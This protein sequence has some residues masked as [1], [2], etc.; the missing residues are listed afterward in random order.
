MEGYQ[1]DLDKFFVKHAAKKCAKESLK[2][3]S[4]DCQDKP[5]KS[6][7]KGYQQAYMD[8]ALGESG[9]VPPVPPEEYWAAHYRTPEGY[10]EVQEWFTGYKLGSEHARADGRYDFN[11]IATPYSLAAWEQP[12]AEHWD[13]NVAYPEASMPSQPP[14]ETHPAPAATPSHRLPETTLPPPPVSG[15]QTPLKTV[16]QRHLPEPPPVQ[17]LPDR[18]PSAQPRPLVPQPRIQPPTAKPARRPSAGIQHT[19][20]PDQK[21]KQIRPQVKE[22]ALPAY[23]NDDPPPSP[24][25]LQSYPYTPLPG[26]GAR[27]DTQGAINQMNGQQRYSDSSIEY[28]P[29]R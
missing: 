26:T 7:R 3:M 11:R 16:P 8:I 24:Y 18:T 17:T 20:L 6:F 19:P 25:S 15:P 21:A 28:Y 14:L 10:M 29:Y 13:G 23:I 22:P 2:T 1:T 27:L 4:A 5:S 12:A 9:V